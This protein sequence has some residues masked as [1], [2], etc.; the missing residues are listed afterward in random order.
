M[1]VLYGYR[2]YLKQAGNVKK[3]SARD[4]ACHQLIHTNLNASTADKNQQ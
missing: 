1:S 3:K 2:A 4:I